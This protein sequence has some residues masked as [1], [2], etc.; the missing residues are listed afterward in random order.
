MLTEIMGEGLSL[1]SREA[2]NRWDSDNL[3]VF[4]PYAYEALKAANK[5]I[6]GLE[7][8]VSYHLHQ[9]DFL[10]SFGADF[11]ETWLSPVEYARKFKK[12]HALKNGEKGF[13]IHISPYQSMTGANADLWGSCLPGSIGK[14]AC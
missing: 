2:L 5:K 6:F 12:M 8:L 7:G 3:L 13:F 11:L 9:A 4:E 14:M 1:L 10:L